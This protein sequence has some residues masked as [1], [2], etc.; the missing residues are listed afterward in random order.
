MS[1]GHG[2][3]RDFLPRGAL[4]ST[5][6]HP[7]TALPRQHP[8][9]GRKGVG[10]SRGW[11]ESICTASFTKPIFDIILLSLEKMK[12]QEVIQHLNSFVSR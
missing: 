3:H 1:P 9:T 12:P 2:C 5:K 11:Q 10:G 6:E 4:V 8:S 7:C